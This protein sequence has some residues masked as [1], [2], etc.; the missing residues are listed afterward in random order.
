M[1]TFIYKT[2]CTVLLL[3]S[4]LM[5]DAQFYTVDT[6]TVHAAPTTNNAQ[7]KIGSVFPLLTN[8]T[9]VNTNAYYIGDTLA[10]TQTKMN[11]NFAYLWSWMT[12]N[13]PY[14]GY[15][16]FWL[17]GV[18]Q[19]LSSGND[20]SAQGATEIIDIADNYFVTNG[21]LSL[22]VSNLFAG[23]T[24]GQ[25][26]VIG[27]T[28]NGLPQPITT[29][30]VVT[31]T[32]TAFSVSNPPA[33]GGGSASNA[34]S[35][36]D[37]KGTNLTTF[38]DGTL[39]PDSSVAGTFQY[40]LGSFTERLEREDISYTNLFGSNII[41][42]IHGESGDPVQTFDANNDQTI[43]ANIF[44]ED[45][46][47]AGNGQTNQYNY[48]TKGMTNMAAMTLYRHLFF[49]RDTHFKSFVFGDNQDRPMSIYNVS[50][51]TNS[52]PGNPYI[53]HNFQ[54]A[55]GAT[56]TSNTMPTVVKADYFQG[57][58]LGSTNPPPFYSGPSIASQSGL[59]TNTTL[60]APMLFT[61]ATNILY[62]NITI[63]GSTNSAI[64]ATYVADFNTNHYAYL[65]YPYEAFYVW[66]N[67]TPYFISLAYYNQTN[68]FGLANWI[69]NTGLVTGEPVWNLG[70]TSSLWYFINGNPTNV[71]NGNGGDAVVAA[72]SSP[73]STNVPATSVFNGSWFTPIIVQ[74]QIQ[75]L[76]QNPSQNYTYYHSLGHT[77]S[78]VNWYFTCI[79][80]DTN[81][82]YYPGHKFQ[83]AAQEQEDFYFDL[84]QSTV[85]MKVDGDPTA[86]NFD[87]NVPFSVSAGG[88]NSAGSTSY[89]LSIGQGSGSNY[90][91]YVIEADI[92]Q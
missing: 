70:T 40:S 79:H 4:C 23:Y 89:Q 32:G 35:N 34:I 82:P 66:T 91:N 24:N 41:T 6:N 60:Y 2:Y 18:V 36:Y 76:T 22:I 46:S 12:T 68:I 3:A 88:T 58:F 14:A 51:S 10:Q 25:S 92:F 78:I 77:P 64:N 90:T 72:S 37:G 28:T 52:S 65:N 87:F 13:N 55:T 69:Q 81:G 17:S 61:L 5:A 47:F 44:D 62:N 54:G 67:S 31:W 73:I 75:N 8:Y 71:W 45:A 39:P 53:L 80:T 49:N 16:N 38:T 85:R 43:G 33:G 84:D 21:G 83:I 27:L 29:G 1:K 11:A 63:S 42:H 19:G 15:T 30:E 74:F 57:N 56:G 59:G 7:I 86:G 48:Y 20:F 50:I 26:S 9:S